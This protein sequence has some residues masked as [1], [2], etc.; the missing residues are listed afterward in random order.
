MHGLRHCHDAIILKV[1]GHVV[2]FI[3]CTI[4]HVFALDCQAAITD[5]YPYEAFVTNVSIHF[6]LDVRELCEIIRTGTTFVISYLKFEQV[7]LSI[8]QINSIE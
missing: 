3:A 7:K 6:I 2:P 8:N 5:T 1:I 4:V